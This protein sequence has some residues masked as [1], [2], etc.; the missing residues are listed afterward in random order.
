MPA[1]F[2]HQKTIELSTVKTEIENIKTHFATK[3]DLIRWTVSVGITT[4]L[5]I[6]G[7]MSEF[8]KEIKEELRTTRQE[9]RQDVAMLAEKI[10]RLAKK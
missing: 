8:R 9:F 7:L 5:S 6:V 4:I 10:D 3:A 2:H 1:H